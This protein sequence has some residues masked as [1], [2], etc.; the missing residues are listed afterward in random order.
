MTHGVTQTLFLRQFVQS[1]RTVGAVLPSS[2]ALARAMLAPID[3]ASAR[4][5][6]EF[7]PGTGAFT[8]EIARRLVPGCRYLGI[9]LNP[10]FVRRLADEFPRLAFVHGSVADLDQ[11]LATERIGA[12]D[13]IVCGLPWAT[14]PI[15]LQESVFAAM[16]RALSPRRVVRDVRLS[17]KPCSA[18]R[19]GPSSSTA[20]RLRPCQPLSR[21]LGERAARLRV[22]LPQAELSPP[23]RVGGHRRRHRVTRRQHQTNRP[24]PASRTVTGGR[25]PT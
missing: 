10:T 9:E 13:A 15:S 14:L 22:Y 21:G 4:T 24:C 7:G 17:P 3:F 11:I 6:V 8:R 25:Q 5:I 16:D 2:P 1:P 23:R 12:I 20:P 19:L 18:R